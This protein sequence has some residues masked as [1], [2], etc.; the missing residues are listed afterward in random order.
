MRRTARGFVPLALLGAIASATGG[1][2]YAVIGGAAATSLYVASD[3]RGTTQIA[4]DAAITSGIKT[5]LL[6]DRYVHGL[7]VNVDTRNGAV[8]LWG[9]VPSQLIAERVVLIARGVK[10]VQEVRS[11]LVVVP[12]P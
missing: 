12:Q 4:R 3:D 9:H 10:N 11:R 1:C 5:K 7:D 6:R 8:T 2:T